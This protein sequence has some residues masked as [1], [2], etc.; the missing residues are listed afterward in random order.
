MNKGYDEKVDIWSYAMLLME[1]LTLER[2]YAQIKR[3]QA[4]TMIKAGELPATV[5]KYTQKYPSVVTLLKMCARKEP[6]HRP[7][8]AE[9]LQEIAKLD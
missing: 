7:T 1:M 5:D 9:I 4:I 6:K 3:D 2:P 8:A